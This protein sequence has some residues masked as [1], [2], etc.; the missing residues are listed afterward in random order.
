MANVAVAVAS[1]AS[2]PIVEAEEIIGALLTP[3]GREDPYPLYAE[4]RALAS[5]SDD[6]AEALK[7]WS[8]K[9]K[10]VFTGR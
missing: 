7:A 3:E 8:E 4:A 5:A 6:H 9:R 2:G 1:G 10:P